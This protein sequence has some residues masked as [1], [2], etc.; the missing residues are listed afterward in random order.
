M[1]VVL[2]SICIFVAILAGLER[3]GL[4]SW[5]GGCQPDPNFPACIAGITSISGLPGRPPHCIC[6]FALQFSTIDG[7]HGPVQVRVTAM[8]DKY[9]PAQIFS[10]GRDI[11]WVRVKQF[12]KWEVTNLVIFLNNFQCKWGLDTFY[13]VPEISDTWFI[14]QHIFLCQFFISKPNCKCNS[15]TTF[16]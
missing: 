4:T 10:F 13:T 12:I 6:Q 11:S 2:Q 15:R 7:Q 9:S 14:V 16:V 1:R 3:G 8:L 5:E